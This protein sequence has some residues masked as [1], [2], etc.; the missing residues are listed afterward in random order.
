MNREIKFR[1]WDPQDECMFYQEGCYESDEFA[2]SFTPDG[3]ELSVIDEKWES[4]E[5]FRIVGNAKFMQFT[6]LKDKNGVEIYE[7][8]I[9]IVTRVEQCDTD[10]QKEIVVIGSPEYLELSGW[11]TGGPE[12]VWVVTEKEVIGNI[13]QNPELME[14][15]K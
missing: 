12:N 4:S 11:D 8:D 13:H 2:F 1:A 10:T 7:D 14:L 6:G 15:E 5:Y 9:A 3:I